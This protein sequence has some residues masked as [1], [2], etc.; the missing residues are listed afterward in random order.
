M[1]FNFWRYFYLKL[2]GNPVELEFTSTLPVGC[3]RDNCCIQLQVSVVYPEKTYYCP[4]GEPLDRVSI[5]DQVFGVHFFLNPL[6]GWS[7]RLL[8]ECVQR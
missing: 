1:C 8:V 3:I 2:G 5:A 7:C 6:T 4:T